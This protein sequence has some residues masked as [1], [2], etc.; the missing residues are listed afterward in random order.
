MISKQKIP[1]YL[2]YLRIVAIAPICVLMTMPNDWAIYTALFLYVLAALTDYLDGY[3]ARLWNVKSD[4]GRFLDPI[5]DKLLIAA[6]I[7]ILVANVTITG[8]MLICPIL[9]LIRE[10]F[11]SGLREYMGPKNVV[12]HVTRTAKWKTAMQL[13]AC[14]VLMLDPVAGILVDMLGQ[15]LLFVATILTVKSGYEYWQA[16]A[17]HMKE[18]A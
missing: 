9:I 13:I 16:M 5:A 15:F 3:L 12:V 14:G 1:N 18:E 8:F 6:V 7:I 2:T 10:L 4:I 11:I 17:P